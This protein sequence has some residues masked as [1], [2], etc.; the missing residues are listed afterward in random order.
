VEHM[1]PKALQIPDG[2]RMRAFHGGEYPFGRRRTVIR[3][4]VRYER[5]FRIGETTR[6]LSNRFA[7]RAQLSPVSRYS[8]GSGINAYRSCCDLIANSQRENI[9]A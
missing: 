2:T 7:L 5:V 8:H 3:A 6:R 1:V 4:G 9:M